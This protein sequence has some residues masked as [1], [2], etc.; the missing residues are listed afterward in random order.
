MKVLHGLLVL[1]L[2]L[3]I[4]APADAHRLDEYLQATR[5]RLEPHQ[6]ILEI[7][8]TPGSSI[9]SD[10]IALVDRNGDRVISPAEAAAYGGAVI[11]EVVMEVDGRATPITLSRVEASSPGELAEGVGTIQLTARTDAPHGLG[12]HRVRVSNLHRPDGSVYLANALLPQTP[13]VRILEQRRDIRQ[14]TFALEYEVRAV[15][16]ASQLMWLFGAGASL[17]SLVVSRKGILP[18]SRARGRRACG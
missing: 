3:A 18:V 11:A 7:D 13:G 17:T 6:I 10:V 14:Q 12:R 4:P 2:V 1:L 9:A 16:G 8:L 15:G 5:L